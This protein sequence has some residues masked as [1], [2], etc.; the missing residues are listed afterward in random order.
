MDHQL[1]AGQR[2]AMAV[3]DTAGRDQRDT[4]L[5]RARYRLLDVAAR[6]IRTAGRTRLRIA[7]AGPGPVTWST[8]SPG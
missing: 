5:V 3:E 4:R 6:I 2:V 8:R 7:E 1:G